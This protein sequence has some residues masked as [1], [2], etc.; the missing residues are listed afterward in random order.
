MTN[1]SKDSEKEEISGKEVVSGKRRNSGENSSIDI[2][3]KNPREELGIEKKTKKHRDLLERYESRL[4]DLDP[5]LITPEDEIALKEAFIHAKEAFEPEELV[6]WFLAL[7]KR[8]LGL[9]VRR[10]HLY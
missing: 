8:R 1:F 3:N 10:L 6:S 5:E 2:S 4:K 9:K 7:W